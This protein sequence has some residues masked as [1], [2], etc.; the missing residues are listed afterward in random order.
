MLY[1][2]FGIRDLRPEE[3]TDI[4]PSWNVSP[5]TMQPVVWLNPET[6]VKSRITS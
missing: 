1:E 5:Q 2:H 6:G 4:A 3:A